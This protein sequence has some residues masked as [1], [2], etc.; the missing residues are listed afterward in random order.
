M[1]HAEVFRNCFAC[2]YKAVTAELSCPS[3]GK[4]LQTETTIRFFGGVL[5]FLGLLLITVM[6]LVIKGIGNAHRIDRPGHYGKTARNAP[7]EGMVYFILIAVLI[8]GVATLLAGGWMAVTGRRNLKLL[9]FMIGL[10][11]ALG[12]GAYILSGIVS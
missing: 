7:T 8:M 10:G 11:L 3:C 9:W 5:S 6:T 12:G 4:P 2:D 1:T